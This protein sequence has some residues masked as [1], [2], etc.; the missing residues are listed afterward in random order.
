M[1]PAVRAAALGL[2][3][4][5]FAAGCAAGGDDAAGGGDAGEEIVVGSADFAESLILANAYHLALEDAGVPVGEPRL[6]LGTREVYF[7]ALEN[8][9]ISFFP[10]YLGATYSYLTQGEAEPPTD[11]EALRAAVEEQ[12]PD[13]LVLL[14]SSEA[15]DQDALAVTEETAQQY[16][17]QTVSDLAAVAGEL[18]AGGPAEE[19]TR[20]TGLPGLREV[21]GIDFADFVVTDAGGPQTIAALRD[22]RIDVGRVFTTS[23]FIEEEGLVV[24]EDDQGLVPPENITPVAREDVLTEQAREVANAVS[25]ALTTEKL[26]ELNARVE[27]DQEDPAAVAR[28]FLAAEGLIEG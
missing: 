21:Y 6:N 10:E 7:E 22:G 3:L 1:L 14:E 20:A 23:S 13:G 2:S 17:L 11:V 8:G 5:L 16:E 18:T 4:L 12:L 26:I 28:D 27:L 15:Q 19:E 25:A 9:E 24:L